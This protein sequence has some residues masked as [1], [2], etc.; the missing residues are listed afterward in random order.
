MSTFKDVTID[1]NITITTNNKLITA[2][3]FGTNFPFA[4]TQLMRTYPGSSGIYVNN[5]KYVFNG[6]TNSYIEF[7][8]YNGDYTYNSVG[9]LV[10]FFSDA[11]LKK[12]IVEPDI[13]NACSLIDKFRFVSFDW[14]DKNGHC[15]LGLLAQELEQIHPAL[16][17][18]YSDEN[19]YGDGIGTKSVDTTTL[20]TFNTKAV[21]E[22]IHRVD[23][24]EKEN[25]Q[26]KDDIQSIKQYLNI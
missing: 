15:E 1:G 2:P 11:R 5:F 9:G 20:L 4:N 8:F 19:T 10:L 21:Q 18:T 14:K 7:S 23:E 22:L 13:T 6:T 12:N 16:V 26:L 17:I 25:K 24:L 3:P